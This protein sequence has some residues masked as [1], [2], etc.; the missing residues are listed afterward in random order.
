MFKLIK[1]VLFHHGLP[2]MLIVFVVLFG[3]SANRAL[4]PV[5]KE[6]SLAEES[7]SEPII[8]AGKDSS[9][10]FDIQIG[11]ALEKE[12]KSRKAAPF[13]ALGFILFISIIYALI[14]KKTHRKNV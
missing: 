10:L 4:A 9:P 1:H 2:A 12:E 8:L 7:V 14:Y 11:P 5:A 6:K 3:W 13:I